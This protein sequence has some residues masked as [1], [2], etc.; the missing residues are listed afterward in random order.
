MK[1][2]L[3]VA[4]REYAENAKTRGFWISLL[5]TPLLLFLSVKVPILLEQKATPVKRF[6]LVDQAGTFAPVIR[7]RLAADYQERLLTALREHAH[8]YAPGATGTGID[9]M[10]AAEFAKRGG[11]EAMLAA[12][13]PYL[14]TNAPAF[15]EPRRLFEE[16]DLPLGLDAKGSLDG[17]AEGLKPYLRG[18]KKLAE[19]HDLS[20]AILIPRALAARASPAAAPGAAKPAAGPPPIQYWSVDSSERQLREHIESAVNHELRREEYT[21]RG[22][23]VAAILQVEGTSA[24]FVALNPKKEKGREAVGTEDIIRQWAPSGF[25]YLLWLAIFVIV[26]MLLNNTIEEKSNRIIEVLLSSVTPGELMMGKLMGIAAV[27]LTVVGVWVGALLVI[28]GTNSGGSSEFAGQLLRVVEG[29]R[30]IPLFILY[31][32]LGYIMYAAFI[33]ALGSLCNTLKEAQS[34]MGVMTMLMMIP[35][36]T[37]TYIP[38]DPNGPLARVLS[39]IPIYTPF[40]MMNRAGADPPMVDLLGTLVML[41]ATTVLA[42]WMAG[43]VFRIGIL[44]T[45]QPPKLM[46][47]LGWLTRRER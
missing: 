13:T 12:L 11:K 43:K 8:R 10:S 20:A 31:F 22:M 30:L 17:L 9:T 23:D 37:M 40:I 42:L 27:G 25:V 7:T 34:Y 33:L 26:Q 6:V 46:E 32:L 29:S 16:V 38:K 1:F 41:V 18:E 35:L 24:P 14:K 3:L 47:I 39:W 15:H 5:L 36:L 44:R 2:A 21:A 19:D 45:G 28:L 4:W